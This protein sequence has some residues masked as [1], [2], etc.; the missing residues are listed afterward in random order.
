VKE[1]SEHIHS[2][3]EN[4]YKEK[5]IKVTAY[6]N[7]NFWKMYMQYIKKLPQKMEKNLNH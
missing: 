5:G 2:Q 4:K 3:Q 6:T 1:Q 7:I